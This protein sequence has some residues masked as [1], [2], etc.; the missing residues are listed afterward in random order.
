MPSSKCTS[1]VLN[2]MTTM[3]SSKSE[4]PCAT[5]APTYRKYRLTKSLLAAWKVFFVWPHP[6][7]L[8]VLIVCSWLQS[9]NCNFHLYVTCFSDGIKNISPIHCSPNSHSSHVS[10]HVHFLWNKNEVDFH[11]PWHINRLK[12]PHAQPLS[13]SIS[14]FAESM[15]KHTW[16]KVWDSSQT[17]AVAAA[18]ISIVTLLVVKANAPPFSLTISPVPYIPMSSAHPE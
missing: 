15:W 13:T 1:H 8:D 3:P 5:V 17:F 11:Q 16:K 14:V 2:H 18:M 4:S 9:H 7:S 12:C 10:K 6:F